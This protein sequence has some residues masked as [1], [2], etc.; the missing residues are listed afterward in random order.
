MGWSTAA[1]HL[2]Q[3]HWRPSG[4]CWTAAG[5][6]WHAQVTR[7]LRGCG[8]G[9]MGWG[10]RVRMGAGCGCGPV[11]RSWLL[12][13]RTTHPHNL[14]SSLL[15][16]LGPS[17]CACPRLQCVL[18]AVQ[19][20]PPPHRPAAGP[21][22]DQAGQTAGWAALVVWARGGQGSGG[23]LA[24]RTGAAHTGEGAEGGCCGALVAVRGCV[25]ES[26]A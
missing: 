24:G 7:G 21:P 26:G 14:L 15:L 22:P 1:A 13:S 16:P 19:C 12:P 6:T 10:V 5:M 20:A 2:V 25:V 18:A 4:A 11:G 23:G 8:V 9:D 3:V 17:A